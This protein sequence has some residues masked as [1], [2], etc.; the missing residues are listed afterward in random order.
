MSEA[1]YHTQAVLHSLYVKV[2]QVSFLNVSCF[3]AHITLQASPLSI[4][5]LRMNRVVVTESS[6]DSIWLRGKAR[7][8]DVA[9][10]NLQETDRSRSCSYCVV[11]CDQ[12]ETVSTT[13]LKYF[14]RVTSWRMCGCSLLVRWVYCPRCW[15]QGRQE[16]QVQLHCQECCV[17]TLW[18]LQTWA[19]RRGSEGT[20]GRNGC[21]TG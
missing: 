8:F 13:K 11:T 14:Q 5:H 12:Q 18:W 15:V 10:R 19:W 16:V 6:C 4:H 3:F 9:G 21:Y 17:V 7:T 2:T 20:C 1:V